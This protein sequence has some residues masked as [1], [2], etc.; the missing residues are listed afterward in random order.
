MYLCDFASQVLCAV[1]PAK[2]GFFPLLFSV[3]H[4]KMFR[5]L[6][7]KN[8]LVL[9]KNIEKNR[10]NLEN[11][12]FCAVK[13]CFIFLSILLLISQLIRFI[14][15]SVTESWLEVNNGCSG[16][17]INIRESREMKT[18]LLHRV[19]FICSLFL[20]LCLMKSWMLAPLS[21]L[22]KMMRIKEKHSL[23]ERSLWSAGLGFGMLFCWSH[24]E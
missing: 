21:G 15:H 14:L 7:R 13:I 11:G 9:P 3:F 18:N 22:W 6:V 5:K 24:F 23:V 19:L 16:L 4:Y 10:K 12:Q 2:E 1:S 8:Y 20:M 17:N